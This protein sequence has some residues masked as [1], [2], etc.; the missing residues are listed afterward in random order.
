M[1]YKTQKCHVNHQISD[2][3]RVIQWDSSGFRIGPIHHIHQ[4]FKTYHELFYF[5]P[6]SPT[7]RTDACLGLTKSRQLTDK[8]K[9]IPPHHYNQLNHHITSDWR[10]CTLCDSATIIYRAGNQTPQCWPIDLSLTGHSLLSLDVG[11]AGYLL[12]G[13]VS[14]IATTAGRKISYECQSNDG[15]LT[16]RE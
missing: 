6:A 3:G 14:K 4:L 16:R 13:Y 11:E 7:H 12:Q 5:L 9:V 1:I 8:S 15:E 10:S 2:W